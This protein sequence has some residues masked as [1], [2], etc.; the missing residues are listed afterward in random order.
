MVSD[1]K[2]LKNPNQRKV[3]NYL[4]SMIHISKLNSS[5]QKELETSWEILNFKKTGKL[6]K[7]HLQKCLN[8]FDLPDFDVE[9]LLT[10][11]TLSGEYFTYG[12]FINLIFTQLFENVELEMYLEVVDGRV[13]VKT[14]S[15]WI[16]IYFK[17][18]SEVIVSQIKSNFGNSTFVSLDD[19]KN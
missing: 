2:A 6:D 8:S 19:F 14:L 17:D 9:K 13:D 3:L 16:D 11:E 12:D 1:L 4:C 15:Q 18:Q 7:I 10:N 5:F